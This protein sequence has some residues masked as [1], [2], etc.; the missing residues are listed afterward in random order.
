MTDHSAT[1]NDLRLIRVLLPA[2]LMREVDELVLSGRGGYGSRQEFLF[3]AVQNQLLEVKH[4]PTE[5]GQLHIDRNLESLETGQDIHPLEK[6]AQQDRGRSSNGS[7]SVTS[8]DAEQSETPAVPPALGG[9]PIEPLTE[10][11]Q[12]ALVAPPRGAVAETGVARLRK[13]PLFGLHNRDYPSIWVAQLLAQLSQDQP[14]PMP[15]FIEEATRQ[16]WRYAHSLLDLETQTKIKLT[17]LFPTN[18]AKPQ[19]AEAGFRAFAIGT[20]ARKQNA[21]GSFDTSGPLFAWQLCQLVKPNGTLHIALTEAGWELLEALDGLTLEWPHESE[22][23]E[24]FFDHL[25]RHAPWDWAGFEQVLGAISELPTRDEL[26]E[27]FIRWQPEWSETVANTNSAGFVARG[28][29]WGL[30][31]P[32]LDE[33]R[34]ALT[35][36]GRAVLEERAGA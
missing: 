27:S 7:T 15:A 28:R 8:T 9:A 4:G 14:M 35:K 23:A 13:E 12:T 5:A 3:D 29:E 34:Y 25:R 26:V 20:I 17:A 36:L 19:S 18:T 31:A 16:A 1:T 32:K 21:D 24:R 33:R 6:S 30:I 22:F 11:S 2:S 10:V